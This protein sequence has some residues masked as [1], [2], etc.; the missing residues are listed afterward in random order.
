MSPWNTCEGLEA[1]SGFTGKDDVS[2]SVIFLMG[3]EEGC[4]TLCATFGISAVNPKCCLSYMDPFISA[5][6]PYYGQG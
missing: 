1:L 3:S 5:V 4:G 6:I 2:D